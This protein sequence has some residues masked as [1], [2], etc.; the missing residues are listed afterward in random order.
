MTPD[1]FSVPINYRIRIIVILIRI[2]ITGIPVLDSC[3]CLSL[4]WPVLL[5][6]RAEVWLIS[7]VYRSCQLRRTHPAQLPPP[8]S[9]QVIFKTPSFCLFSLRTRNTFHLILKI[10]VAVSGSFGADLKLDTSGYM[11]NYFTYSLVGSSFLGR[12]FDS[13]CLSIAEGGDIFK[14]KNLTLRVVD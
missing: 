6:A 5:A 4:L 13:V 11:Q 12:L 2:R 3:S 9:K 7:L 14:K 1:N 8:T 10:S